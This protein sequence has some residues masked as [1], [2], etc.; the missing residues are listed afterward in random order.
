MLKARENR[1]KRSKEKGDKRKIGFTRKPK[2]LRWHV[3]HEPVRQISD[4]EFKCLMGSRGQYKIRRVET[5]SFMV[6]SDA[7]IGM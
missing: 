5:S 7:S 4:A 3:S 6:Y 2:R 1:N